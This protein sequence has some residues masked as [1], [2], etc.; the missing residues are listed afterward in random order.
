[1]VGAL[2]GFG[3]V[4]E[5]VLRLVHDLATEQ[6]MPSADARRSF[7]GMSDLDGALVFA[8]IPLVVV[9]AV[10]ALV[11]LTTAKPSREPITKPILDENPK[12]PTDKKK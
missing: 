12:A 3:S 7:A 1:M 11:F 2:P 6:T 4:K 9:A 10:F 5:L 8:G